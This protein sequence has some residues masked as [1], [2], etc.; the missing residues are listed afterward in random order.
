MHL[1]EHIFSLLGSYLET[2]LSKVSLDA[3]MH[4]QCQIFVKKTFLFCWQL[5]VCLGEEFGAG[6][7][8]KNPEFGG[9]NYQLPGLA[10]Q[11]RKFSISMWDLLLGFVTHKYRLKIPSKHIEFHISIQGEILCF[12]ISLSPFI[13]PSLCIQICLN[14]QLSTIFR[15]LFFSSYSDSSHHPQ[16]PHKI[17]LS[18]LFIFCFS[19]SHFSV[20]NHCC[21]LCSLSVVFAF[22]VF[23]QAQ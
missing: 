22:L 1:I 11:M 13:F 19:H 16:I 18:F 6:I 5:Y 3:E 12:S 10:P 14:S 20:Y 23:V 9:Q 21:F 15:F 8:R 4:L 2:F 17:S 7:W